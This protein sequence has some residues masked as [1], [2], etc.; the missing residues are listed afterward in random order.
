MNK[1]AVQ[2]AKGKEHF[3]LPSDYLAEQFHF[4]HKRTQKTAALNPAYFKC[5]AHLIETYKSTNT[6]AKYQYGVTRKT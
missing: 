4:Y 1:S 3:E 6:S 5:L 2:D